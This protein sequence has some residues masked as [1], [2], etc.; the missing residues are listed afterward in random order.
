MLDELLE[1]ELQ[2]AWEEPQA[3]SSGSPGAGLELLESWSRPGAFCQ[4]GELLQDSCEIEGFI[5]QECVQCLQAPGTTCVQRLQAPGT[6]C[7]Q[8]LQEPRVS[9][10]AAAPTWPNS[11]K[12]RRMLRKRRSKS[13]GKA[14]LNKDMMK[15]LRPRPPCFMSLEEMKRRRWMKTSFLIRR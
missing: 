1:A 10:T 4:E 13:R 8:R 2:D 11:F 15:R 5:L 7:V 14:P 9:G 12:S 6:M 3:W